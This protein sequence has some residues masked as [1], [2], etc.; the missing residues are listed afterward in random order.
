LVAITKEGT[1]SLNGASDD[2]EKRFDDFF[3]DPVYLWFKRYIYSYLYR[4][5]AVNKRL[6]QLD[7]EQSSRIL[8]IGAGVAPIV[9]WDDGVI[10]T[11]LSWLALARLRRGNPGQAATMS[12]TALPLRHDCADVI[13]CSE[14]LEHI[15]DDRAAFAEIS[16][17]LRPGGALI[18]TVPCNPRYYAY[19]DAFVKHQRRYVVGELLAQLRGV[20][21]EIV[22]VAKLAGLV[23]KL[24]TWAIVRLFTLL[25]PMFARPLRE[26]QD[27]RRS[28]LWW[29]LL[30]FWFVANHVFAAVI[31][32][33]GKLMPWS[34]T[35]IVLVHARKLDPSLPDPATVR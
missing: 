3:A 4:K 22:E 9:R 13:V 23:E 29:V 21:L 18:L 14:V 32:V 28:V 27:A 6:K 20:Q 17:A 8:E 5:Y 30:P 35:S 7:E 26:R 19:D 24:T 16:R 31:A 33:E 34:L 10:L 12:A 11:D 25:R 1:P 2:P 15:V